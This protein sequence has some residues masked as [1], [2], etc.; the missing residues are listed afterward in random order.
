MR[1][2]CHVLGSH[3]ADDGAESYVAPDYQTLQE[4]KDAMHSADA[5]YVPIEQIEALLRR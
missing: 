5:K 2:S 4:M 3:A 1:L